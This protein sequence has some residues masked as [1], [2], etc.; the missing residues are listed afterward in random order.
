MACQGITGFQ[1]RVLA[2]S[3]PRNAAG[4]HPLQ[5]FTAPRCPQLELCFGMALRAPALLHLEL[6]NVVCSLE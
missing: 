6:V 2:P 5:R 4:V 3:R 1:D